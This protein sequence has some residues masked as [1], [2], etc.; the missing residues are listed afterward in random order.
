MEREML[1]YMKK[2]VFLRIQTREQVEDRERNKK[3][4]RERV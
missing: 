2:T 1:N 4:E 3:I